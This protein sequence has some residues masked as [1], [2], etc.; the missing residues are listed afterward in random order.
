MTEVNF[1]CYVKEI[2]FWFHVVSTLYF[3]YVC[4]KLLT[5][6]TL[7]YKILPSS[8]DISNWSRLWQS[9]SWGRGSPLRFETED[10]NETPSIWT[11]FYLKFL[12]VST[13]DK[14]TTPQATYATRTLFAVIL[15]CLTFTVTLLDSQLPVLPTIEPMI[16]SVQF[17]VV[18]SS[19]NITKLW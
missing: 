8:I 9:F 10:S 1:E 15:V 4:I 12:R 5:S 18:D 13:G 2:L 6:W 3:C 14:T 19:T 7:Q 17:F 16:T 11:L